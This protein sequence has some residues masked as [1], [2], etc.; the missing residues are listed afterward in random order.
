MAKYYIKDEIL[1]KFN[2]LCALDGERI[3]LIRELHA[4]CIV[5]YF[6]VEKTTTNFQRYVYFLKMQE[7][8]AKYIHSYDVLH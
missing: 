2:N 5:V 4:S 1:Y 8:I 7:Q 6:G 3:K